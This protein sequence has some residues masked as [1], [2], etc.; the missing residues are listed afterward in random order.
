MSCMR[1]QEFRSSSLDR[2][3]RFRSRMVPSVPRMTP[4][5]QDTSSPG[6]LIGMPPGRSLEGLSEI[7]A[8][9]LRRL[10]V[11][12]WHGAAHPECPLS[13]RVLEDKQTSREHRESDVHD[14]FRT[15]LS[16]GVR[17]ICERRRRL[18]K[19]RLRGE[20]RPLK[21]PIWPGAAVLIVK[22][23]LPAASPCERG[24]R[25]YGPPLRRIS[26]P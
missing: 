21:A 17:L 13:R 2:R 24:L 8:G 16:R 19:M 4:A 11:P 25:R 9:K 15:F 23:G 7:K 22:N 20:R 18:G 26:N 5:W 6:A 1:M 10:S 14:P 12:L 3:L